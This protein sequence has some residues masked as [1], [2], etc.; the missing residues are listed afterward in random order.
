MI[1][2]GLGS[3]ASLPFFYGSQAQESYEKVK[4]AQLDSGATPEKAESEARWA[5]HESGSIEA[6]GELIAD[7]IP[8]AKLL[9]P[10]GKPVAKVTANTVKDILFPTFKEG[11]KTV[12]KTVGAEVLTEMGQQAGESAVEGAH[13]AGP[14]ATWDETSRVIMPTALMVASG[15]VGW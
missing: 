13:G 9:K 4:K 8:F 14:G 12:G 6:G 5:A 1:G 7:V 15:L 3:L 10:L 2:Y 11:A